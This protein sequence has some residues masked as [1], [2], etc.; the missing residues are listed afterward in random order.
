[1]IGKIIKTMRRESNLTQEQLSKITFIGRSTL[2]DYE[3]EKTDINFENIE[4][5]AN[6]CNY[7][8]IFVSKKIIII[9]YL[10]KILIEKKFNFFKESGLFLDS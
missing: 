2:S 3:R 7:K 6:A 4:K 10:R 1:M 9:Y 8:I 5:I